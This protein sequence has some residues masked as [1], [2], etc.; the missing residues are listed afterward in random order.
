M[1]APVLGPGP[2]CGAGTFGVV[3]TFGCGT[4]VGLTFGC[5][6]LVGLAVGC[7][8][9]GCGTLGCGTLVGLTVGCGTFVCAAALTPA[10]SAQAMTK[11]RSPRTQL[12][13]RIDVGGGGLTVGLFD[14]QSVLVAAEQ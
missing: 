14:L 1:F 2:V 4:F 9:L 12:R 6:T 13:Y 5:G 7:G 10:V 11:P 8:T 3:G